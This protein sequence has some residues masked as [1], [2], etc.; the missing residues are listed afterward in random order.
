MPY[1]SVC[2]ITNI[3]ITISLFQNRFYTYPGDVNSRTS[4][5]SRLKTDQCDPAGCL[6]ELSTLL[7]V[8]MIFRQIATNCLE[9]YYP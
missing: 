3:T 8:Y 6:F 2:D 5:I 4:A 9:I 1:V 7:F